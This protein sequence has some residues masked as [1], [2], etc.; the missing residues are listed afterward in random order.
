MAGWQQYIYDSTLRDI[1][2]KFVTFARAFD[3]QV[4]EYGRACEAVEETLRICRDQDVL[5]EYLRDEEAATIMFTLLDEQRARK[6]WEEELLQEGRKEGRAEGRI[7]G[8]AKFS[9]LIASLL[10]SGRQNDALRVTTDETYRHQLYQE[11][12]IQ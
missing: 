6:F 3:R 1:I 7:E 8:E 10:K 2:N 5:K 12:N 9:T 4:Q 11:L